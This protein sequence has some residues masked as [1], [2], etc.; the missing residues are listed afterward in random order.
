DNKWKTTFVTGLP[1]GKYCDVVTG[2]KSGNACTGKIVTV[3]GGKLTNYGVGQ[4]NAIAIHVG[5]KL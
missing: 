3:R 5:A 2:K 4:H 1:D